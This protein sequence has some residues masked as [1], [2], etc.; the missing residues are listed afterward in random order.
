MRWARLLLVVAVSMGAALACGKKKTPSPKVE[1]IV[2]APPRPL[3][4]TLPSA[5]PIADFLGAKACAECHQKVYDTWARSPHGRSMAPASPTTVLADFSGSVALKDGTVTLSQDAGGY[6]MELQSAAGSERRKVDLVLAAGRQHQLY[7]VKTPEG[8]ALLP[9]VWSTKT[10]QWLPLSLYQPADLHPGSPN[11]W[12]GKDMTGGCFNCHLSQMYRR[13]GDDPKT[14]WV[15]LSINCESCHGPGREHVRRRRAGSKDEVYKNLATLKSV[16]ESRVC[17]PCHGFQLKPYVFPPASDSLPQ[18]FVTSLVLDSLRPDGTQ[19][20][21]S[22]QYAGHVLSGGFKLDVLVCNS[23]HE[24]HTL[25]ARD[26]DG[27]S[28]EGEHSNRQCTACHPGMAVEK[29]AT[30][31]S[32]HTAKVRCVDCHM[33]LS[34]IGDSDARHQ[35]TSD[36]SISSPRPQETIDFGTP[37]ACTTCHADRAPTWALTALKKWG[38]HEATEVRPWVEAIALARKKAPG[39]TERLVKLLTDPTTVT[40]LKASALDLLVIQPADPKLVAVLEPFVTS[41]DPNLR[42]IALRALDKHDPAGRPRWRAL[43]LAD[44]HPFVRM[45]VFSFIEDVETLTPAAIAHDLE[46]TLAFKSP[47]TDGLVHLITVRHKRHELPEAIELVDLL[48]RVATARESRGL[49]L[50]AVRARLVSE[51]GAK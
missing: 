50:P 45:E 47:P 18:I 25:A 33:P 31:H 14:E 24:P 34:W 48:Q 11:Y 15:D 16:D 19:R 13:L 12:G 26:K 9:I 42:A 7:A 4:D 2:A 30:A 10:K 8:Q 27:H 29:V 51:L 20:L 21:T 36:H 35:Q 38:Y 17:G 3:P 39:S 41:T 28:A 49:N 37:N 44:A 43:G 22:Y 32:H 23:C 1:P 46:D 6:T 5:L 40:F